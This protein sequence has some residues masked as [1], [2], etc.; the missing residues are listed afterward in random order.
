MRFYISDRA[1][2]NNSDPYE[3]DGKI[4]EVTAPQPTSAGNSAPIVNAGADQSITLPVN[5]LTL[6][7]SV[8]DDGLP[9]SPG[10]TTVTWNLVA[11]PGTVSF[12]NAN[13]AST[14][15]AFSTPG[16]Y[17]LRLSATDSQ[18]S[19]FDDVQITVNNT[20][21]VTTVDN[22]VA[23]A[24]DDAEEN[25]TGSVSTTSSDLEL[26]YDGSNQV[27]GLRF[28]NLAIPRNASILSAYIQFQGEAIDNAATFVVVNSNISTRARTTASASWAPAAWSLA[29]ETGLNQRTPSLAPIVQEIVNRGGWA[30]GNALA[31]LFSGTG[32]RT[33]RAYD[34]VA[35]AAPLLHIE[36]SSGAPTAT[37]TPV[38][39]TATNTPVPP[40]A[41]N[42]PVPPTATSTFTPV[43][44]TATNTPV[45]PTA[46]STFTPV[47]PTATNTPAAPTAT[48]TFTPV[49]PTATNTPVP[50]TATN[51][52]T[53][54][55]PT[56]TP[57]PTISFSLTPVADTRVQSSAVN[58]NYGS[59]T[60]LR[61]SASGPTY[62]SYLKFTVTGI[63]GR[64]SIFTT[65]NNYL[66]NTT[67]WTESGLTWNNSP[68]ASGAALSTLGNARRNRW[69]EFNVTAALQSNG[70]YS[71]VL[72]SPSQNAVYFS[73]KEDTAHPPTLVLNI[74]P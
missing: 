20:S 23:A 74:A 28:A 69:V 48:S 64:G 8:S 72:T 29:G 4:F 59:Q 38:P 63:T 53:P 58:S 31:I 41:T 22:R 26:V 10:S 40:T 73:A 66:N 49:P 54:I 36:Y 35:A 12:G 32:H 45:A 24:S 57:L 25:A 17:L 62:R 2:D 6:N 55:P 19:S 5:S 16:A 50:P 68:A 11:G 1:V 15:A 46:T 14:T 70:T 9:T 65:S 39:P 44:P 52:F 21:G 47:P 43:P 27:V 51:T 3:N 61:V 7:G 34:G 33:A 71:F 56:A 60:D 13:A 67:A 18:L 37:S 42:T 30:S